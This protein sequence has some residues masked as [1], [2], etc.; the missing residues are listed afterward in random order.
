M[1]IIRMIAILLMGVLLI[2]GACTKPAPV[3]PASPTP[4]PAPEPAPAQGAEVLITTRNFKP[5]VVTVGVGSTVI[6]V[7]L[8]GEQHTVTSAT[9]L[10]N[11]AIEPLGSFSYTFTERGTFEYYCQIYAQMGMSGAVVVK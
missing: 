4:E 5:G 8:D 11:G 1:R 9:G 7:S 10:F 2:L 6:W 3:T